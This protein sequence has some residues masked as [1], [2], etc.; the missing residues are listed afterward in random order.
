VT[1]ML[2]HLHTAYGLITCSELESNRA[3]IA[4]LWTPNEPIESLWERLHEVR[5]IATIGNDPITDVA[6]VDLT[7]LLLESTGVFPL[8]CDLWRVCMAANKTIPKLVM[9]FTAKNKECLCK[10][11]AGPNV[12]HTAAAVMSTT[13]KPPMPPAPPSPPVPSSTITTND[14]LTMYYCWTHGLGFNRTHTSATC[15]NLAD[16]HCPNA[17]VKNMQGGNKTIMSN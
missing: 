3:S 10:L 9:Y 1:N 4:T 11:M 13:T 8:A 7:I 17:T 15:S 12:F 5:C 6:L 2:L 14:G 16:G